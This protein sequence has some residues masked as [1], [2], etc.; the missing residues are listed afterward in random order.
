MPKIDSEKGNTWKDL[1]RLG[2]LAALSAVVLFIIQIIVFAVSPPPSTVIGY[3]ELL[4]N[5]ALLGLLD[6]DLLSIADYALFGLLFLALYTVLRRANHS[7]MLVA[8]VLELV[9]VAVYFAS[10]TAFSLLALS[11]QYWAAATDAQRSMFEGAG[12]AML[13]S[14]DQ[15]TAFY[16][17]YL[18]ATIAPLIVSVVML[19]SGIFS[20]R[21]AYVGISANAFGLCY[22]VPTEG[23]LLSIV[24]VIGLQVWFILIARRLFQISRSD[25][26]SDLSRGNST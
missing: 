15:G 13:V 22:F 11:N 16:V 12:W 23:Q 4:R 24:S 17:S 26:E 2:G 5:N 21:V 25:L 1:S 20:R 14:W 19:H 8:L 3:F 7:W 10:N 6:L 18:F 9:G